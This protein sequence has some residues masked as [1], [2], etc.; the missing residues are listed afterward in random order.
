MPMVYIKCPVT[1]NIISTN[2]IVPDIEQLMKEKGRHFPIECPYCNAT[3][4]WNDQN[5]FFL[6]PGESGS[7]ISGVIE[8]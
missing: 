6:K 4:I 3:H 5:G 7:V 2:H 8:I 1:N